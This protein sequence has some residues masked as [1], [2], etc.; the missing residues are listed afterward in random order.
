MKNYLNFV[1][2]NL[3][4]SEHSS[5]EELN[6]NKFYKPNN[7][8]DIPWDTP[9]NYLIDVY[10][11]W[12]IKIDLKEDNIIPKIYFGKG[13]FID[14]YY[15]KY[16]NDNVAYMKK[17]NDYKNYL[18]NVIEYTKQE[19][20]NI[21]LKTDINLVIEPDIKENQKY[22][23]EDF[24]TFKNIQCISFYELDKETHEFV[25]KDILVNGIFG[26]GFGY[27]WLIKKISC[28]YFLNRETE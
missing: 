23:D 25:D 18:K 15:E 13:N 5:H 2:E 6:G 17:F 19:I 16:N 14:K 21:K 1:D 7:V 9:K 8:I 26:K 10:K 27:V 11:K 3:R 22:N 4:N 24:Y 12:T 20:N 28:E